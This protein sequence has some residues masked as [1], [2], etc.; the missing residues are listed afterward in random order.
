MDHQHGGNDLLRRV[1]LGD[2]YPEG[3]RLGVYT[4]Y[5]REDKKDLDKKITHYIE[6]WTSAPTMHYASTAA[7]LCAQF[8]DMQNKQEI[9][10]WA[11][12]R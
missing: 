2:R 10:P 9:N 12:L 4:M 5:D 8:Y 1:N 3:Q 11:G 6:K 7:D